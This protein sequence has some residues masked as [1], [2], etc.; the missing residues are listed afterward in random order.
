MQVAI[1]FAYSVSKVTAD[2]CGPHVAVVSGCERLMSSAWMS[3]SLGFLG[4]CVTLGRDR[5]ATLY[6]RRSSIP[7][8]TTQ[9][10]FCQDILGF[11]G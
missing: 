11:V 3:K 7:F 5:L 2:H 4:W 1:T 6:T 8:P 9:F 10:G